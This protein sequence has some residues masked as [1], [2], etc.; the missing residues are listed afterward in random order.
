MNDVV[1]EKVRSRLDPYLNTKVKNIS[2]QS[3]KFCKISMH[4]CPFGEN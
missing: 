3:Y 4:D 1:F 2:N